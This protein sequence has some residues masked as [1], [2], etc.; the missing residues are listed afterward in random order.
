VYERLYYRYKDSDDTLEGI[1]DERKLPA[2]PVADSFKPY[3]LIDY[4]YEDYQDHRETLQVMM[5]TDDVLEE[6]SNNDAEANSLVEDDDLASIMEILDD[7]D[8]L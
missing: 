7:V 2:R 5:E 3:E 6:V 4:T 1:Y 8:E